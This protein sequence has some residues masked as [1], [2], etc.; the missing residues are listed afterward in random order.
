[1]TATARP[2]AIEI[3][4][5]MRASARMIGK[6]TSAVQSAKGKA[7]IA[8]LET[9]RAANRASREKHGD[10]LHEIVK[11]VAVAVATGGHL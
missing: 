1:M 11:G 2:N 5:E 4:D 8:A 9:Y 7:K 10:E 3:T 6:A